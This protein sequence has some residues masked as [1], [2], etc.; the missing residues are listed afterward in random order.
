VTLPTYFRYWGKADPKYEG[1]PK[2]HPLVY[3]SLDVAAVAAV[4]WDASPVIRRAFL[5]AFDCAKTD[6]EGLQAWVLFFIALHDIG[7][8][9]ARFQVKALEALQQAWPHLGSALTAGE[10]VIDAWQASKFDHGHWGYAWAIRECPSWASA[11]DWY[12]VQDPWRPW[13]VAVTG[14][15]GEFTQGGDA[16]AEYAEEWVM[17]HD[18]ESRQ[19]IA[20]AFAALFLT[21]PG[22]SLEKPPPEC[23]RST[24]TLLAGFCSVCDWV[25]SNT[26]VTPYAALDP[27]RSLSSYFNERKKKIRE[28]DWLTGFG[29]VKAA[30]GYGGLRALLMS[31]ESPRGVQVRIDGL[32]LGPGLTLIEAPTGTGKTEAALAYAWRL[33]EAGQAESIIFALP[34]QATANA[35]LKRA[36]FFASKAYP[37]GKGSVVLAHGKR[38]LNPAFERLVIAGHFQTAQG[39]EEATAQCTT[40]LA[41]SRKRVFLG[42]VGVCTVDQVLLSVLPVR[43]SFVRG[44]GLEKS[45]LIID[46]VHAYDSYMHG[47]LAEVLR[48]QRMSGGSAI[49]LSATLSSG[50]RKVF[51]EAWD[52]ETRSDAA[53]PLIWQ[54]NENGIQTVEVPSDQQ[55]LRQEVLV[56]CLH[57]ANGV[58]DDALLDRVVA[59]A[60]SGAR[61]AVVVNLVDV[62]QEL[63][64]RLSE[65]PVVPVDL[66]HAR[67]RFAD[68]QEK[69][70][71]TLDRY[72]REASREGGR[73]LVATQVV[74]QSLDLDFDWMVTQIC[75]VDLLFQRLGRLHRHSR[76]R[77]AGFESPSCTVVTVE[78][79]DF[80]QHGIIY[81]NTRVLWRTER[82][83]S[84][85]DRI[86]FPQAYREW[87]DAVYKDEE[88]QGEP[89]AITK[90]HCDFLGRRYAAEWEAKLMIDTPFKPF[91]DDD[92][93]IT[94]KTRDSEMSLAVLPV[95]ADGRLFG[96]EEIEN[97]DERERAIALDLNTVPV[98]HSWKTSLSGLGVD[99]DGRYRL[100]FI[101]SG[102]ETWTAQTG[103]AVFTYTKDFGLERRK[104]NGSSH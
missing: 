30:G 18:K 19:D 33:L 91:G 80:G 78:G 47:L 58:P 74:E 22:F 56:E 95:Q 32:P 72:G 5:D 15:H 101:S 61:V 13:L 99:E 51:F 69:E 10:P 94:V 90:A 104:G 88:W 39:R 23:G 77:P 20:H 55:P 59:A 4:W 97:M 86:V 9:D 85:T 16:E 25:G 87:I 98:P 11:E 31:N 70:K 62:A 64:R 8:C 3:H 102:P 84:G 82:L 53:Y 28:G 14:H 73:I 67:F 24:Q 52:V 27:A 41:Q 26:E 66:F 89:E 43:H 71:A 42:Q 34:T 1:E 83:L 57:L 12:A 29:L 54:I 2:W 50:V 63:A 36:E 45:V 60:R 48:R 79:Q 75:P 93:T 35:M 7:K 76:W 81:E 96:R 68:R 21:L 44:F 37:E 46:E 49:L 103:S 40:W 100:S 17:G 6:V 92:V 38:E 65:Q